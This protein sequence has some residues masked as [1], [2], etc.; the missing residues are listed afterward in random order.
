MFDEQLE[1]Y[2]CTV[3]EGSAMNCSHHE[4]NRTGKSVLSGHYTTEC[5]KMV[6]KR[7]TINCGAMTK[8]P[9]TE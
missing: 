5:G 2:I 8:K 9:G 4:A 3:K 1:V 7:G 6:F